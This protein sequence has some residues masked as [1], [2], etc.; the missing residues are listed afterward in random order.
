MGQ[1]TW[2][3]FNKELQK[4]HVLPVYFFY[5]DEPYLLDEALTSLSNAIVDKNLK[6]F[7]LNTFYADS[8]SALHIKEAV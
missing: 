2:S 4:K 1:W 6:D 5:G 7:N 8:A 3:Q